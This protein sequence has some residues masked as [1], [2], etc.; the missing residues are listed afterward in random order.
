MNNRDPAIRG[1]RDGVL[2]LVFTSDG[3][4]FPSSSSN[5]TIRVWDLQS[6][7]H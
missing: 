2:S 3:T 5:R 6:G 4:G 7:G 1:R